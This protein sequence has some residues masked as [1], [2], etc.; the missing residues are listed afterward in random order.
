MWHNS[1]LHRNP[2]AGLI[3]LLELCL[4]TASAGATTPSALSKWLSKQAI[5]ELRE[6]LQHYP[7]YQDQR[8]AIVAGS[9]DALS[10]ALV[11]LMHMN[12]RERAGI[13]LWQPDSTNPVAGGAADSIDELNCNMRANFDYLLQVSAT[14]RGKHRGEVSLQLLPSDEALSCFQ[15]LFAVG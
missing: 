11:T 12:L 1:R 4:L 2:G 5:P 15:K 14:Q 8:I 9:G 7:R 13:Q 6:R 3:L 10:E